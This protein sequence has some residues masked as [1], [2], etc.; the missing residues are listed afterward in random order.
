MIWLMI[1][2]AGNCY[3][4]QSSHRGDNFVTEEIYKND[5]NYKINF[6]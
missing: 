4:S 2:A 3:F 1:M 5:E 6:V